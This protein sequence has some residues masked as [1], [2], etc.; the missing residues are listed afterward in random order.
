METD[1]LF[2]RD[3][4]LVDLRQ[5]GQ[6][7]VGVHPQA[8]WPDKVAEDKSIPGSQTFHDRKILNQLKSIDQNAEG[9]DA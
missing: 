6:M 8:I 1:D 4:T 7:V 5:H 9:Y 3:L 2:S